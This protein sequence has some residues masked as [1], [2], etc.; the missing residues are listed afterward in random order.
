MSMRSLALCLYLIVMLSAPH[1][2]VAERSDTTVAR[3]EAKPPVSERV[4]FPD[5]ETRLII[6]GAGVFV[7]GG[8]AALLNAKRKRVDTEA[9][10][11]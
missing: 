8:L 10:L 1:F 9:G 6:A 5:M 4:V 11:V 3:I 2:V 7:L